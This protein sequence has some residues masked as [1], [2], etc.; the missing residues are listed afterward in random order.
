MVYESKA[1]LR[2]LSYEQEVAG[3]GFL[4]WTIPRPN[5]DKGSW[6]S[7]DGRLTVGWT[8]LDSP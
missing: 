4:L 3:Y 2:W 6:A 8:G 7:K 5:E 1:L